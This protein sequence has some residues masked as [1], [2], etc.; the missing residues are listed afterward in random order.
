M[1]SSE[2]AAANIFHD[3]GGDEPS[4]HLLYEEYVRGF[5][6]LPVLEDA[7]SIPP[8]RAS[9]PNFVRGER[10]SQRKNER[11]DGYAVR[12]ANLAELE[13]LYGEYLSPKPVKTKHKPSRG[14]K[15]TG[16]K[17]RRKAR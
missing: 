6:E 1:R 4:N 5:D 7:V 3:N 9:P 10:R 14:K 8:R 2:R 12:E 16:R 15:S 13:H 11:P 17:R